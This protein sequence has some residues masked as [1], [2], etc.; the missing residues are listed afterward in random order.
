MLIPAKS[1]CRICRHW[2]RPDVRV[3]RRQRTCSLPECQTA[4]RKKTQAAW[5]ARNPGYSLAWRI[6][7]RSESKPAPDPLRLPG[8]LSELPWDMA[9]EE[10]G[11]KGADFVG[12]MGALLLRAA[13][14][15]FG[16][17]TIDISKDPGTLPQSS[18]KDQFQV[19]LIDSA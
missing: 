13:K 17:Q 9:H 7:T 2:F 19:Q 16:G 14:D 10:F 12:A 4:R 6:Q 1:P 15:Q 8:P 5:R 3:G 18:A 11:I